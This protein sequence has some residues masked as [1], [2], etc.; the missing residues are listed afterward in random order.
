MEGLKER[1][2]GSSIDRGQTEE[3]RLTVGYGC[4]AARKAPPQIL[5]QG[6]W[7][8]RAGFSTGDKV[9]VDCRM[10]LLTITKY[11]PEPDTGI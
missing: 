11:E 9:T 7:L 2:T 1:N 4:G 8:E 3:H 6:K 10:G 5:L